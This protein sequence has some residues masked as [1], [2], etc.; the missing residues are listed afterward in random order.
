[1]AYQSHGRKFSPP[2]AQGNPYATNQEATQMLRSNLAENMAAGPSSEEEERNAQMAM[3]GTTGAINPWVLG[4]AIA[5]PAGIAA[6]QHGIKPWWQD[7]KNRWNNS[8]T[9]KFLND[10]SGYS[11]DAIGAG[12]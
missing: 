11:I 4:G 7:V 8:E 3:M 5:L 10:P 2:T 1:M 12:D 9:G 6:Y